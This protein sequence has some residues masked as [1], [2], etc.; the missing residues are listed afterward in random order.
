M[1]GACMLGKL[2][3]CS[4]E[5]S[6]DKTG[7]GACEHA[8]RGSEARRGRLG[9]DRESEKRLEDSGKAQGDQT[10]STEHVCDRTSQSHLMCKQKTLTA[11]SNQYTQ[12]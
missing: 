1:C 10:G 2:R 7:W 9:S 4:K 6:W 3:G 5:V 11:S 12:L 8:C